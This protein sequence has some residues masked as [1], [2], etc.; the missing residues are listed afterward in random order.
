VPFFGVI[1]AEFIKNQHFLHFLFVFVLI[2]PKRGAILYTETKKGEQSP[3]K[4]TKGD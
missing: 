2:F 3:E 4:T 1:F